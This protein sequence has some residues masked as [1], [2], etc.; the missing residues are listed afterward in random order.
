MKSDRIKDK[1]DKPK[2]QGEGDGEAARRFN[3]DQKCF[4]E[5]GRAPDAARRA[6]PRDA[7][8]S[9]DLERA[10][11]EGR[12]RAKGEDPNVPGAN[13]RRARASEGAPMAARHGSTPPMAAPGSALPPRPVE[14]PPSGIETRSAALPASGIGRR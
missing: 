12:S 3:E 2:N 10:E 5:T 8:E 13:A 6:A 11:M 9:A 4:V 1:S 14:Q 7:N